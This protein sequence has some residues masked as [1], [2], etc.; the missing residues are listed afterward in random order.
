MRVIVFLVKLVIFI[1]LL[2]VILIFD[3]ICDVV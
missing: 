2:L 1:V 3:N